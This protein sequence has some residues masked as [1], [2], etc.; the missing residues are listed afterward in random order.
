MY[1]DKIN[2][3][4]IDHI[5][6]TVKN[7]NK[8]ILFY[9]NVLEM[10]VESFENPEDK[11]LRYSAKFG[12]QKINF[13]EQNNL[14]SPHADKPLPGTVDICFLSSLSLKEWE[15]KLKIKSVPII[16]GPVKKNGAIGLMLSI[17]I[18]DPDHNLIEISNK[19]KK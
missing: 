9:K 14:F 8:S 12:N 2:V 4:S 6:M 15:K 13:H 5:V 19:I 7:L 10:N 3:I 16:H 11:K 1:K 17:Y 18:R